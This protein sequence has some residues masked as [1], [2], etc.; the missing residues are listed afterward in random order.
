MMDGD[1]QNDP[2]DIP[3][4]LMKMNEG[5]D[6]VSGWRADRHDKL[7]KKLFSRLANKLRNYLIRDPIHDSGCSLKAFKRECFD[8]ID[9]YGEMH[10]YIPAL[11][12]WKGFRIGEV[13]VRHYSRK[14]GKT[15]YGLKRVFRG[16]MD[17]INVWFWRKYSSRPL[18]VF[19]GLG[20]ILMF[21]SGVFGM[22]LM[23]LRLFGKI[24]LVNSSLP[25]LAILGMIIGVQ[26]FISG[27]LADIAIK[28]YF[29]SN[30][31][32]TYSI[33]TIIER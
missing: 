11:L 32:K 9:L 6:V 15:K 2:A 8:D 19:G 14:F 5:Y 25:S 23:Y 20:I 30:G 7:S 10:R 1:L 22:Y 16:F 21:V 3:L 17:L 33:Q 31:R 29:G 27:L 4:L 26:F 28:N 24:S 12:G 13:K 18:H